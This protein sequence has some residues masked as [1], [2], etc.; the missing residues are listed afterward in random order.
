LLNNARKP[1]AVVPVLLP[2]RCC[3]RV[4]LLKVLP[5]ICCRCP[6]T[7][8]DLMPKPDRSKIFLARKPLILRAF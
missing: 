2:V 4:D 1:A 7:G 3:C 6:G 5:V 8:P